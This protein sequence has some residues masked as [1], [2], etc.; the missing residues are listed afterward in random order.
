MYGSREIAEL[1]CYTEQGDRLMFLSERPLP[2]VPDAIAEFIAK[3][4]SEL[5][6]YTDEYC[7][8]E[9]DTN[10]AVWSSEYHQQHEEDISEFIAELESV[11]AAAQQGGE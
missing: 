3:K 8:L 10:S 2:T 1:N 11:L 9:P 5:E 7:H 6:Q 4:K